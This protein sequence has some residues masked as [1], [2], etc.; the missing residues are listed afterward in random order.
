M[1][2]LWS[3]FS[4]VYEDI[5]SWPLAWSL[6]PLNVM[7]WCQHLPAVVIFKRYDLVTDFFFVTSLPLEK[8]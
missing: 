2:E 4:N 8:C 5:M 1:E 7:Q 6:I 3:P